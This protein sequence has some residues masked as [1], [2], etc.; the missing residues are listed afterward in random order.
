M[1]NRE[2]IIKLRKAHIYESRKQAGVAPPSPP[3]DD[4]Q[5]RRQLATVSTDVISFEPRSTL[6]IAKA[7]SV[8]RARHVGGSDRHATS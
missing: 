1:H 8:V 3:A 7:S 5:D 4:D 2:Y 6:R